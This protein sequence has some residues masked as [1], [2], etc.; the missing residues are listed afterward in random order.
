MHRRFIAVSI[1]LA[2][3][4]VNTIPFVT[5]VSAATTR[6]YIDPNSIIDESMVPGTSFNITIKVSDVVNLYAY[7]YKIYYDRT[8]LNCTKAARPAGHFL[9]PQIDPG[10]QFIPKWEIKNDFNATHGRIWLSFTLLAPEAARTGSGILTIVTFRVQGLGATPL[11]MRDTKLA[12]NGGIGITHGSGDSFFRNTAPS[13]PAYIYVDPADITDPALTPCNN[14]TIDIKILNATDVYSFNF[15]LS[16]DPTIVEGVEIAEGTFLS[17]V[18]PTTILHSQID[19]PAGF[20]WF[21]VTLTAP[22]GA[23]GAGTLATITFHVIGLGATDLTLHDT[24]LTDS[25][26]QSLTHSTA[27]GRFAN[28]I[29]ARLFV[30]PPEI[31]DPTIV[32][33]DLFY[34]Y[35]NVEN[36]QNLFGYEFHLGYNTA[37]LTCIGVM[38]HPVQNETKFMTKFSV[39]DWTGDVFVNVTYLPGANP[40]STSSP[41]TL[42]TLLFKVDAMGIS[43]LPLHDTKLVNS[44]G[45]PIPHE[46]GDGFFQ[47]VTRDI[48]VLNITPS[49]TTI[50]EGRTINISVVVAN[51]GDYFNE[52]FDI[53]LYYETTPIA[54]KTV[55]DLPIGQNAT[56]LFTWITTG[57]PP[58]ANYTLNAEAETVPYEMDTVDNTFTDGKI[59]IKLMGDVN[60]DCIVDLYDLTAVALAFSSSTGDPNWNPEADL[61]EDGTIDIFD[62]VTIVVNYGRTC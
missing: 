4:L 10:S 25:G 6:L 48:A 51:Q 14:F 58:C 26:A 24:S 27:N 2:L 61:K 57:L 12:D 32:P 1:C 8:I 3:L 28:V 35:I 33:G 29:F 23:S 22:P 5:K 20:I 15:K 47:S 50:Y 19:N 42:I 18:G 60:G 45:D 30:D 39:D 21:S 62:I 36:V 13:L 7:E 41:L 31:I 44:S 9:E 38:V 16:F 52:T 49:K 43:E 40:I 11:P 34:L 46:T 17:S 59:R 55:H 53:T 56:L 54:T 37:V